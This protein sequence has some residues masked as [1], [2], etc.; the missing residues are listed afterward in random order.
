MQSN[1]LLL[2]AAVALAVF[3]GG[4]DAKVEPTSAVLRGEIV[5]L[6]P[7]ADE[8]P[9]APP[10]EPIA[11]LGGACLSAPREEADSIRYGKLTSETSRAERRQYYAAA[12]DLAKQVVLANFSNW[13]WWRKLAEL[14]LQAE[15]PADSVATLSAYHDPG[16]NEVDTWLHDPAISLRDLLDSDAFRQSA[17][18]GKLAVERAAA[19]QRRTD[20]AKKLAS[21]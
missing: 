11:A 16:G 6:G 7:P 17:L 9:A 8:P 2:V 20:A 13:Y 18:A 4:R 1:L 21:R 12:V 15:R 5:E 14:Q 10:A 19:D 3:L